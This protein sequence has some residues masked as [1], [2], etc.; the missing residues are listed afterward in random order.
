MTNDEAAAAANVREIKP[1][2]RMISL[3]NE[4][5]EARIL[6]RAYPLGRP[7]LVTTEHRGV[8]FGYATKT[9]GKT[10]RLKRCRNCI[11]WSKDVK[12]FMGLAVVGPSPACRVGPAVEEMELRGITAV[13]AVDDAAVDRWEA[14]PWQ[15]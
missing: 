1:R 12:G 5:K 4:A 6:K 7:V 13:A 11:Y 8:F 15:A 9:S 3:T 2:R 14:A 10:I